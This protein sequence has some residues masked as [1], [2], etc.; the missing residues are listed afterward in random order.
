MTAGTELV[1]I[2]PRHPYVDAVT[3]SGLRRV[4]PDRVAGWVPDPMFSPGMPR[5]LSDQA[6]L[7]HLHFGFDHLGPVEIRRWLAELDQAELPLV[8]TV[9]DLR[10]PHHG[11]PNA[12]DAVL[13]VLVP[14]AAAVVTLTPGA[15]VEIARRYGRSAEVQPHPRR[16]PIPGAVPTWFPSRAWCCCT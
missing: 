4:W 2:P 5:R 11:T 7:V 14:A 12:H 16:W 6:D 8:L 13:G 9:H 1:S 3:P 10:N 15:A